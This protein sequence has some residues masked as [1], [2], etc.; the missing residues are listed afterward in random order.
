MTYTTWYLDN[1]YWYLLPLY[2]D[3]FGSQGR[4]WVTW[5]ANCY[6]SSDPRKYEDD[7]LTRGHRVHRASER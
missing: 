6:G 3:G 4:P 5:C 2:L 7:T 1:R